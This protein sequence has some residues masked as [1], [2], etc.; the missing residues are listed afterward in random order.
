MT[1]ASHFANYCLTKDEGFQYFSW[2]LITWAVTESIRN[3]YVLD[4]QQVCPNK[5]AKRLNCLFSVG[6][7]LLYTFYAHQID[8][9]KN[10]ITWWDTQSVRIHDTCC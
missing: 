10:G 4:N 8:H 1:E 3:L 2:N 7:L 6:F 9:T 5:D